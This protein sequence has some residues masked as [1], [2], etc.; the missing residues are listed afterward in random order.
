MEKE[1]EDEP[2]KET[3]CLFY[4]F[5][6]NN[7]QAQISTEIKVKNNEIN[8]MCSEMK[9]EIDDFFLSTQDK[10]IINNLKYFKLY[11]SQ[12]VANKIIKP[13]KLKKKVKNNPFNSK[14]Y[15]G[16]FFNHNSRFDGM[17]NVKK[18]EKIKKIISKSSNYSFLKDPKLIKF[19][20]LPMDLY[21]SKEDSLKL[22]E[23][24]SVK[25]ISSA[26][27]EDIKKKYS[28]NCSL[29]KKILINENNNSELN[30]ENE[31]LKEEIEKKINKTSNNNLSFNIKKKNDISSLLLKNKSINN[32][33]N[34]LFSP[35]TQNT[36]SYFINPQ[37]KSQEEL[38]NYPPKMVKF[39]LFDKKN[40]SYSDLSKTNY[41]CENISKNNSSSNSY[42]RTYAQNFNLTQ[43]NIL[44]SKIQEKLN[45]ILKY[46]TPKRDIKDL[47]N[48][49]KIKC[50]KKMKKITKLINKNVYKDDPKSLMI[51]LKEK[52]KKGNKKK[53][54]NQ[55]YYDMK[56]QIRLLSIVDNL[57]NMKY[58]V[59]VNLITHLNRDY[60]EKSKEMIVDDKVTKQINII[61]RSTTEGKIINEKVKDKSLYINRFLSKNQIEGVKLK[62]KYEKCE[63][64]VKEINVEKDASNNYKMIAW[65]NRIKNNKKK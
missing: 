7:S 56:N 33:S 26:K 19:N 48:S 14:I 32:S 27:K 64:L 4:N 59:P 35:I 20:K 18:Y 13:Q 24:I 46:K 52:Q 54:R 36:S 41:I 9:S 30:I 8:N 3:A 5:N 25:K 29:R 61:H 11:W 12:F 47:S 60:Y 31:E 34:S 16:S 22:K 43:K 17:E 62:N 49:T 63:N 6:I 15:F 50:K 58:N 10:N 57:K 28:S 21:L 2:K 23:L 37:N 44:L 51:L 42:T 39:K 53:H 40:K 38:E 55:F 45:K 65:I 1:E